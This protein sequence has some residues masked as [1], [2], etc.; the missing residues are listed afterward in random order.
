MSEAIDT[1]FKQHTER[2]L[3]Q[4]HEDPWDNYLYY[5]SRYLLPLMCHQ[6]A[7]TIEQQVFLAFF[8]KHVIEEETISQ[9]KLAGPALIKELVN[10]VE[11]EFDDSSSVLDM[12]GT[13]DLDDA[14]EASEKKRTSLMEKIRQHSLSEEI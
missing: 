4:I 3:L 14:G 12:T 7:L 11:K 2:K 8:I 6:E 1:A 10:F 9:F 13:V 5:D